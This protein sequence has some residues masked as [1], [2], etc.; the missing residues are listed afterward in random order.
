MNLEELVNEFTHW[1][2]NRKTQKEPIPP[3][4]WKAASEL[5]KDLSPS[6]VAQACKVSVSKLRKKM[7]LDEAITFAPL[8]SATNTTP[9]LELTTAS[10][11][12]IKVYA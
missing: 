8:H 4:L 3:R 11:V 7:G 2:Q 12:S 9:I 1:R 5:A 10:G 6:E